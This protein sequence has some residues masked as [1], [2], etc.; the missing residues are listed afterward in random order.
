MLKI[1]F[2]VE[3]FSEISFFRCEIEPLFFYISLPT[4]RVLIQ[5]VTLYKVPPAPWLDRIGKAN[6]VNG[7]NVNSA[8]NLLLSPA[9]LLFLLSAVKAVDT[10]TEPQRPTKS[11]KSSPNNI[12]QKKVKLRCVAD[13]SIG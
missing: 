6:H 12:N 7:V 2:K 5:N 3:H 4:K 10:Q 1:I 9:L 11:P 13:R 8:T